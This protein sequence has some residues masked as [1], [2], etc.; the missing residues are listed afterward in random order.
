MKRTT[1]DHA[2]LLNPRNMRLAMRCYVAGLMFFL[3]LAAS[4]STVQFKPAQSYAVGVN[5]V[6]V[7]IGDFNK[8]GNP[9]LAVLNFGYNVTMLLGKGDGTFQSGGSF[10]A[11]I[12]ADSAIVPTIVI[13]D[14][15]GDGKADLAVLVPPDTDANPGEVHILMGNGDGT[16]QAPIVM[17][18]APNVIAVVAVADF[19]GDKKADLVANVSDVSSGATSVG[20]LLGNGD[21][22][23]QTAKAVVT[24]SGFLAVADFNNDG[25]PDLA[26]SGS[27]GVQIM[28]G[29]GDGTFL[30]GGEPAVLSAGP[31]AAWTADLSN[32][33]NADLIV[34]SSASIAFTC[35][36]FHGSETIYQLSVLLGRGD[37]T[38]GGEQIFAT[39]AKGGINECPGGAIDEP[40]WYY[41]AGDFNGDGKLDILA[42]EAFEGGLYPVIFPGNGDGT[43]ASP[44]IATASG[45]FSADL[46]GDQLADLIVLDSAN[47]SID[48]ILNATPA[49]SMTA[50]TKT[51]T[52]GAGQQITDTLSFTGVNGFASTLQLSCQVTGPAPAPTCSL[53]PASITLGASSSTS[54]L[55]ITAPGESAALVS[56]RSRKGRQPFYAIA[57][58]F[59]FV[60]LGFRRKRLDPRYKLWLMTACL[61]TAALLGT[62][63]G[64]GGSSSMTPVHQATSYTVKVTAA[65]DSLT[66]AT[67][68]SLTVQ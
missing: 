59:A 8:D 44:I 62:A 56:P 14:F 18:L 58:P 47:N 17:T 51:L 42:F 57:L 55:S 6:A 43:F 33:N 3:T 39:G 20:V 2:R 50:S 68:I 26:V 31:A 49:F 46:N 41:T 27:G 34:Y 65:S 1:T 64:G 12:P 36:I 4:A 11:G 10:A 22:T 9:D 66:K 13:G 54:T 28:L 53:S 7:A 5:P 38:L 23:F 61:A 30:Q 16:L 25:K 67:Q 32:D 63:C 15:N 48:V 35:G 45:A 37:G 40:L 60:G 29:K 24:D 52:D 19:D 21:G